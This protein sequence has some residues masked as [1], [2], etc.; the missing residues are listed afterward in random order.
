MFLFYFCK[1]T[2]IFI[3]GEHASAV[4]LETPE[5]RQWERWDGTQGCTLSD[6]F[7][8][9]AWPHSTP[10]Q[11]INMP[12]KTQFA[13]L[14]CFHAHT[15]WTRSSPTVTMNT[16]DTCL[17]VN[18]KT[19]NSFNVRR[20]ESV[21]NPWSVNGTTVEILRESE[22][23]QWTNINHPARRHSPQRVVYTSRICLTYLTT[24]RTSSQTFSSGVV[25]RSGRRNSIP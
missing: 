11:N 21:F 3:H 15:D 7:Q 12:V 13:S 22:E 25:V 17:L 18:E 20:H 1:M 14:W 6:T 8:C 4:M 23:L 9:M 10:E 16:R 5:R 2:R 19:V 24:L